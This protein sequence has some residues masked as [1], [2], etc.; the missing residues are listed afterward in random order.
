MGSNSDLYQVIHSLNKNEKRV[1]RLTSSSYKKSG[2]LKFLKLYDRIQA[3]HSPEELKNLP[4]DTVA[5]RELSN[6]LFQFLRQ[7][8]ADKNIALKVSNDLIDIA[9]LTSKGLY[10]LA[11]KRIKKTKKKATD[12]ELYEKLIELLTWEYR[13]SEII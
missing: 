10:E 11:L 6:K 2:D 5:Q 8:N 3:M 4:K 1:F 13:I 7:K 9:C 12:H